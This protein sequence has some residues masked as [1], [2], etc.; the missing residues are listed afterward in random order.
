MALRQFARGYTREAGVRNL[1]RE[2][3]T[4]CRKAAR[5]IA[6][7][8]GVVN[9]EESTTSTRDADPPGSSTAKAPPRTGLGRTEIALARAGTS[10]HTSELV[11]G[12]PPLSRRRFERESVGFL[13]AS[14]RA[15]PHTLYGDLPVGRLKE[16]LEVLIWHAGKPYTAN[17]I[18]AIP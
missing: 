14:T 15:K 5:K 9:N 12:L 6:E 1:E 13:R 16:R 18:L 10:S 8:L 7:E 11:I 17:P 3:G 2:I 4:V